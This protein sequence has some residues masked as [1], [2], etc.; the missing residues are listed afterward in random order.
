MSKTL[1]IL[2]VLLI[3]SCSLS[4]QQSESQLNYIERYKDI[5]I[6]EMERAGIPASIKLA[7]GLLESN[8][9]QSTLARRANN[10]FGM[11]CGSNWQGDT[12]YKEDDDYDANGQL[13]RSFYEGTPKQNG[14]VEFSIRTAPLSSGVYFIQIH[15]EDGLLATEKIVIH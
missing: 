8:A 2:F 6:R 11:K 14:L 9:G 13:I 15:T 12:F 3:I 10:H 4:A 5:A 7:Q 1:Q